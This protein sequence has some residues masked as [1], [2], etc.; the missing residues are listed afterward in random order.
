MTAKIV[1]ANLRLSYMMRILLGAALLVLAA[2]M[3]FKT[4]T[5]V[6]NEL[7]AIQPYSIR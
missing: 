1:E 5:L 2:L 3:L 4:Q 7:H 6:K